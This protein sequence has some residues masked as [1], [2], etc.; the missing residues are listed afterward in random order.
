MRDKLD[1][2]A[3]ELKGRMEKDTKE[4]RERMERENQERQ[5]ESEELR[6]K[7]ERE[8]GELEK[9]LEIG[10]KGLEE[11]GG[12]EAGAIQGISIKLIGSGDQLK[13]RPY[14][15]FAF[16]AAVTCYPF[17][18]SVSHPYSIHKGIVG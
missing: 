2:E 14:V 4:V 11:Q 9:Q 15:L 8:K 5:R 1:R 18:I 6:A 17:S 16:W 12:A 10:N 3:S 13:Q 7:M